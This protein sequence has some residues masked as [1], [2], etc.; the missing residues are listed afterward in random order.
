MIID[1]HAHLYVDAFDSDRKEMIQRAKEANV[2]SIY[3]PNIDSGSIDQMHQMEN[4]YPGYCFAMMGL[5]PCSVKD[6]Y[7]E[8]LN[9]CKTFLEERPYV[10][11]G[12]IGIDLY[13]DK[14]FQKEQ[15]RAFRTQIEWA[16]QYEIPF[17]IHSRDSLD[18]TIEI[19]SEMQQGRL[20]GIFHCFTGT[21]EQAEKIIDVGFFMG[22]G[23][24]ITFKNSGVAEVIKDV[25]L[26]HLVL[27]TDSPY[28]SPAPYRGK[29]NESAFLEFIVDKIAYV[30]GLDT[31]KVISQTTKNA[32][33]I[34]NKIEDKASKT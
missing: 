30:K 8:E 24:V 16:D 3:L 10:S 29:R 9:I 25:S 14:S 26:K 34:F 28:L 23:G 27:E 33:F 17:V 20:R 18:L 2:S 13:W 5:H 32:K 6:N 22:V 7:V 11:I 12:E 19:V 21:I 31:E 1:T 15:E 4:D